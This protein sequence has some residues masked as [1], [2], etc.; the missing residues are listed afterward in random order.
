MGSQDSSACV[1]R[2]RLSSLE[3][4]SSS[5]FEEVFYYIEH[6]GAT[7]TSRCRERHGAKGFGSR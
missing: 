1:D 6:S 5:V 7:D 2:Q 4:V 3:M